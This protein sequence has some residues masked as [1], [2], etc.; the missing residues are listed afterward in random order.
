MNI[1]GE[2]KEEYEEKRQ[3]LI[4]EIKKTKYSYLEITDKDRKANELYHSKVL[5][6]FKFEEDFYYDLTMKYKT[7]I[8]SNEFFKDL[9]YMP[10][11][12]LLHLHMLSCINV[13]WI[14]DEVIKKK[15]LKYIYMRQSKN[16]FDRL[17]FTTQ[18][19]EIDKPFKNII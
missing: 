1:N 7:E 6:N 15:N 14:A 17:V 3:N 18:P 9:S 19:K 8:E 4:Q 11:G 13:Q 10:K 16:S 12:C 2:L 5:N